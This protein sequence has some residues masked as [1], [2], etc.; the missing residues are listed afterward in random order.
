M[1]LGHVGWRG[2]WAAITGDFN[3]C[4]VTVARR[5][6]LAPESV[7]AEADGVLDL[8]FERIYISLYL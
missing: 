5:R 8:D 3:G 4:V 7:T 6:M 1:R 2:R